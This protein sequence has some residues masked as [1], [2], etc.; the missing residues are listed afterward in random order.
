MLLSQTHTTPPTSTTTTSTH[1]TTTPSTTTTTSVQPT[2]T[3]T[4]TSSAPPSTSACVNTP[5]TTT[6]ASTGYN[7]PV[8]STTSP[9]PGVTP[10]VS[11]TIPS[12]LTYYNTNSF[13]Y[14]DP[15]IAY[16]QQDYTVLSSVY[17][18]LLF[19]NGSSAT[20]IVPWLAQSYTLSKDGTTANF[21][22][23]QGVTFQDGEQ[24]N[25]SA[26]YFSLNRL[27]L[28]DASS[29]TSHASQ[30]S[31]ILQQLVNPCLSTFFGGDANYTSAYVNAWLADNFV[32][33]TGPYTFTLHMIH[34][35]A[36]L[37]YMLAG[38]WALMMAP[39]W[40]MN[41]DVALWQQQG[42]NL[43]NYP[44]S[45][46]G[47]TEINNYFMDLAATCNAGPT[48]NGCGETSLIAD[49][50]SLASGS[51]Y[52][53]LAGTG[54]YEITSY[55]YA[56]QAL[57][58]TANPNYWGGG[59]QSVGPAYKQ[60]PHIKTIQYVYQTDI[61]TRETSLRAAANAGQAAVIDLDASHLFD[62]ANKTV[63][64]GG[65]GT[66]VPNN[67][68][69]GSIFFYQPYSTLSVYF[70][71][72]GMN[73]TNP[74]TGTYYS[75]QPFA[76]QRI[77]L[78]FADSVN[79]TQINA[80][81]NNGIGTVANGMYP[82]GLPPAGISAG[83]KPIYS[84][85]PDQAA[86]LLLQA[87][88][89]PITSFTFVNGTAAPPGTFTTSF[90]CTSL[91]SGGTCS[92]PVKQQVTLTV[93][94]GDTVDLAAFNQIA[95][96]INNISSTY[97][98]G[99]TV[100]VQIVPLGTLYTELFSGQ[101]YMSFAGW[102]VDYPWVVDFTAPSFPY[103]GTWTSGTNLNYTYLNNL[104]NQLET[105]TTADNITGVVTVAKLMNE[106]SLQQ[107]LYLYTF[108]TKTVTSITFTSQLNETSVYAQLS[109]GYLLWDALY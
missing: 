9:P 108:N 38:Q 72:Y 63:W 66:L 92:N 50:S 39:D 64:D 60:S 56:T 74:Q 85:N 103:P 75:F 73:V 71:T 32:Q 97:N 99:L 46:S 25:S 87:M 42:Y 68:W 16:Y 15:S 13:Q 100:I 58:L 17:E 70:Y 33:I 65:A 93:P 49:S 95:S 84:Y 96:T 37:P 69:T 35:N 10:Y 48:P 30:A 105:A 44:L 43:P 3:T 61:A 29:P 19:Y 88:E 79:I 57:T 24:L 91:G 31:W 59:Y 36:A 98:M 107:V 6:P 27:L 28:F 12:S 52:A 47:T 11:G 51:N 26:V 8:D 94:P 62:L 90:G 67:Q 18:P 81:Y 41:H 14:L 104:E 102:I 55:N 45:G 106:F 4:T 109:Y 76:D 21:T 23:R 20:Q 53:P 83:A 34:P 2:T 40:V 78:A 86:Q 101:L 5:F 89:H 82:P 77:R 22:L 54:P 7:P 80:D 1:T